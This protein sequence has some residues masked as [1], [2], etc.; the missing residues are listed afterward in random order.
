ME[1]NV[2]KDAIFASIR[3]NLA[4]SLPFDE[5]HNEHKAH[6][7]KGEIIE[8]FNSVSSELSLAEI[9]RENLLSIGANCE[10]VKD[11]ENAARLIQNIIDAK[12]LKKIAI[13]DA[14]IVSEITNSLKVEN[15]FL[16]NSAKEILFE[17][18]L[19]ITSAQFGIA[20][21][22]TLVI[23]SD[24]EFNR[25]TSL[26]P[27]IH[28]CVLETEKIRQTLGEVLS[29]LEKDLSRS[30]TFITGQSRTSDIEL[31]LALGVHGPGELFVILVEK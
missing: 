18:D 24:K 28:I 14:E 9:F 8:I 15:D 6:Q 17:T 7:P 19:G 20:E 5:I 16:R 23:E 10:I 2:A 3:R 12:N 26:V 11:K 1:S 13:S 30:I 21:A 25:L 4:A 27:P 31:T 22:G 29:E